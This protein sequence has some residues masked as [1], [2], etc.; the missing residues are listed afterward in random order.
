MCVT[1]TKMFTSDDASCQESRTNFK[2]GDRV[3]ICV[4]LKNECW[5]PVYEEVYYF[6]DGEQVGKS[7]VFMFPFQPARVVAY[8]DVPEGVSGLHTVGVTTREDQEEGIPPKETQIYI[9]EPIPPPPAGKATLYI[10]TEPTGA[11]VYVND[12][13]VGQSPVT[14]TVDPG[15]Y[16]I[17]AELKGYEL[18]SCRGSTKINDACRVSVEARQ[19][20][21][22]VTLVLKKKEAPPW[23][24]A[25]IAGAVGVMV[26][27]G[28]ALAKRRLG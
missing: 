2:V 28:L 5:V 3:Y 27:A 20:P 25:A 14:V 22:E 21:Y 12:Q 15:V 23:R 6:I 26:G 13:L 17:R 7:T 4:E 24:N 16:D 10:M 9:Q 18:A 11:R 1:V 19:E 8:F